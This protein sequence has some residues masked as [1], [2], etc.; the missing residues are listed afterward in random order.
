MLTSPQLA[1]PGSLTYDEIRQFQTDFETHPA[2][3]QSMNAITANKAS[4]VALNRRTASKI[5]HSFSIQLSENPATSQKQSGRCWMFAA[6]NLFRSRAQEAMNLEKGFEFSQNYTMFWDKLEK[7]NYFLENILATL[8]EPVGSRLLDWLLQSPVQDGGQWDMF[9]NL[10]EK[11]GVVPKTI[12]PE[13]ES[14]SATGPM[15]Q[16]LT[17]K[18]REFGCRLRTASESGAES[19][20]LRS[21]K[22]EF[23]SEIYRFLV[24]HL[25]E[26]PKAFG[27]QWRDK[28]KKFTRVDEISPRDFYKEYVGFDLKQMVCLIHDPRPDHPLN[29]IY[30]VK[31]LGNVSGGQPTTYLNTDLGTI[32]KAAIEQI[33]KGS[34]VWFGCDVGKYLERDLGVMDLDIYDYESVYGTDV[35]L[36][37]AERLMYGHSQMTHAM[38]F[39]GVD[40]DSSGN[41]RKWRVEN[42]WSAEPGDKGFFQMSDAWFDQFMY[43]V[44]VDRHLLPDSLLAAFK[45]PVIE[46]EPWDPMGSLA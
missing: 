25:G 4:K 38:V 12:M 35:N 10:I 46:L 6:L 28:D 2:F 40:L 9:V 43:E 30:T 33:E 8:N 17:G 37:K 5:D 31:F 16:F 20:D 3:R 14:S 39:T 32:K 21:L 44:V 7:A 45:E 23:M 42:S 19:G 26:P 27:Y 15:N 1:T 13:T 22:S 18:L 29:R 41:S 36:S 34:S 11:Y 24:I